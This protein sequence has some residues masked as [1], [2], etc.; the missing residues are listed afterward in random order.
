MDSSNSSSLD[1]SNTAQNQYLL[2]VY[3]ILLVVHNV[4][5]ILP[6]VVFGTVALYFMFRVMR[7]TGVK[8]IMLLYAII[9]ICCIIGSVTVGIFWVL[10]LVSDIL[11]LKNSTLSCTIYTA[12]YAVCYTPFTI[13]CYCIAM[14]SVAQ[15]FLL[16]SQYKSYINLKLV[17]V[18][19]TVVLVSS[20]VFVSMLIAGLCVSDQQR[21]HKDEDPV[22]LAV[23]AAVY[24]PVAWVVP[25]VVIVIFSILTHQKVKRDVS[26]KKKAIVRSVLAVIGFNMAIYAV[27]KGVSLLI[28]YVGVIISNNPDIIAKWL[29]IGRYIS[30]LEY[31]F[32]ILSILLFNPK[33]RSMAL[34]CKKTDKQPEAECEHKNVN[35]HSAT[36]HAAY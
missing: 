26:Y 32:T 17:A 31:P 20:I 36:T 33:L 8:P 34:F 18:T 22:S 10:S 2:G 6:S 25:F 30:F 29:E 5:V 24:T 11:V 35:P 13:V 28:Y 12:K 21:L 9:T 15:F 3:T 19:F 23:M 1:T 7:R 4:T 14:I 27:F 16:H